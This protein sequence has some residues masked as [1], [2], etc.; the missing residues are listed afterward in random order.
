MVNSWVVGF[1]RTQVVELELIEPSLLPVKTTVPVAASVVS[2]VPSPLGVLLRVKSLGA[3]GATKPLR[4]KAG[5]LKPR[6]AL[7]MEVRTRGE[8]KRAEK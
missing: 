6:V 7:A 5:E 1:V 4:A 3:K 2:I 8:D